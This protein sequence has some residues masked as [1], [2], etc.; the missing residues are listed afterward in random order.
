LTVTESA[1]KLKS[2]NCR[3]KQREQLRTLN[4]P[5]TNNRLQHARQHACVSCSRCFRPT[6]TSFELYYR[7]PTSTRLRIS[8]VEFNFQFFPSKFGNNFTECNIR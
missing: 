1:T 4:A 2:G 8:F 5:Q 7:S 6:A 3:P